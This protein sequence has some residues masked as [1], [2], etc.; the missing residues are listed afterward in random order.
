MKKTHFQVWAKVLHISQLWFAIIEQLSD[1]VRAVCTGRFFSAGLITLSI[2]S[3]RDESGISAE[4]C[5][6]FRKSLT[7]TH[8]TSFSLDISMSQQ[9]THICWRFL[10]SSCSMFFYRFCWLVITLSITWISSRIFVLVI[11][12]PVSFP[13][14]LVAFLSI[15]FFF[16]LCQFI[17]Y[18]QHQPRLTA[19]HGNVD[20]MAGSSTN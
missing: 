9:E 19:Q 20:K 12:F 2:D 10:L 16:F 7:F 11:S 5:L 3:N 1:G 17:N 18:K 13:G 6:I 15:F 14:H 4:A 8:H